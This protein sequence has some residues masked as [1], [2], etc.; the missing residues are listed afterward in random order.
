MTVKE[1][2]KLYWLNRE[3]EMNKK[4][5][6][7]LE[8][9]LAANEQLKEE[10]RSSLD[11]ISSPSIDGMPH[12]GGNHSRVEQTA[13][14]LVELEE[15][16]RKYRE[17]VANIKAMIHTRQTLIVL[18]CERLRKY[19]DGIADPVT[20]QIFTYR[21]VNGLPW[22]QVAECIGGNNQADTVKKACYR[23]IKAHD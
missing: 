16:A 2:S 15:N 6:S 21:F 23:Y 8:A 10:L 17:A 7:Q 12:G 19:I 4:Q 14:R 9:D 1:L 13:V 3:V 11:G 5:L 18:E 22:A 20:R